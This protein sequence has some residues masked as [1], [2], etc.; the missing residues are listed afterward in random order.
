MGIFQKTGPRGISTWRAARSQQRE[1]NRIHFGS[2]STQFVGTTVIS[3]FKSMNVTSVSWSAAHVLLP[4]MMLDQ[5]MS[6]ISNHQAISAISFIIQILRCASWF[7]CQLASQLCHCAEHPTNGHHS[8][9]VEHR[10][11]HGLK[12]QANP[13]RPQLATDLML[14][15][16]SFR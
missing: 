13:P 11:G 12:E 8:P 14:R 15:Y 4:P 3:C 7:G 9:L 2:S 6:W 1:S 5:K 10:K 16:Y